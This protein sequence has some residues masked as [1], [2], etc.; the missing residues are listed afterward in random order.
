MCRG[1]GGAA[2]GEIVIKIPEPASVGSHI[3]AVNLV[4]HAEAGN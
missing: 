4:P 2:I 3:D 1:K